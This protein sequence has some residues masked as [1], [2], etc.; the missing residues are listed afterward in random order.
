MPRKSLTAPLAAVLVLGIC[1]S[2]HAAPSLAPPGSTTPLA[3]TVSSYQ[4]TNTQFAYCVGSSGSTL[5]VSDVFVMPATIS[6]N[7]LAN[8]W[9]SYLRSAYRDPAAKGTCSNTNQPSKLAAYTVASKAANDLKRANSDL[10]Q[11]VHTTWR[12]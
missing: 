2:A 4:Q 12:P 8:S 5:P 3:D 1:A 10:T 9:M 7:A 6:L 11:I